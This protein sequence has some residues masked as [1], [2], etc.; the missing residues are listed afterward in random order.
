MI[1]D[2]HCHI[3]TERFDEDRDAVIARA[4]EAE[5]SQ[6]IVIGAGGALSDCDRA[7]ELVRQHDHLW[8]SVGVHPHHA[9][10][11]DA[12]TLRA[13]SE[14]A[15]DPKVVAIGE[16]G[17]DFFYDTSPRDAQREAFRQFI[18]MGRDRALPLVLHIRDAHE[19]AKAIL[20]EEHAHEVG[21]VVHCFTGT[22][23]DARD[24]LELGFHLGITG[25]LTFKRAGDLPAV[26]KDAPLD[27]LLV[28]TDSPY[29]APHPHRGTRN[30][31]AFVAKVV[32]AIAAIR[33]ASI[34]TI[35]NHTTENANRLFS[36]TS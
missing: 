13:I 22:E 4:A 32:E 25:I 27:R 31:P 24:Y 9:D 5:V 35:A 26:V 14:R 6:M 18:R 3:D 8:A 36:L 7:L 2:S 34:E 33:N 10:A 21:G 19:E 12:E 28:E 15:K 30:E 1:T 29:L 20:A 16:T 11:C 17:L 23:Q